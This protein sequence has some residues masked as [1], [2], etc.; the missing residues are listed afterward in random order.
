MAHLCNDV[1]C[2]TKIIASPNARPGKEVFYQSY[3][4]IVAPKTT[5][6]TEKVITKITKKLLN[7]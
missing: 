3:T 4:N 6:S 1:G 2:F 5:N 7:F